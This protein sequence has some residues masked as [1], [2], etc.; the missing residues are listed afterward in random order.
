MSATILSFQQSWY[1]VSMLHLSL[2]KLSHCSWLKATTLAGKWPR[3]EFSK[4]K[5]FSNKGITILYAYT[6][7]TFKFFY[8]LSI[9][10]QYLKSTFL[11]WWS[12]RTSNVWKSL[13]ITNKILSSRASETT[14]RS[15]HRKYYSRKSF[16][17]KWV[18]SVDST[19]FEGIENLSNH[20][21]DNFT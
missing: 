5:G 7:C 18:K 16:S 17:W 12:S 1:I 4:Y 2:R 21:V 20:F 13:K 11:S 6:I 3:C 14:H 9:S 8:D 10:N 15:K 19:P